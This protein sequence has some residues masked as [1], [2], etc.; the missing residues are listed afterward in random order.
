MQKPKSMA[1]VTKQSMTKTFLM[2]YIC[3]AHSQFALLGG[4]E[5]AGKTYTGKVSFSILTMDFFAQFFHRLNSTAQLFMHALCIICNSDFF[6]SFLT[7]T[8]KYKMV[9]IRISECLACCRVMQGFILL[10]FFQ[11]YSWNINLNHSY[12]THHCTT[13]Q[14]LGVLILF[15]QQIINTCLGSQ[16]RVS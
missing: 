9:S 4:E 16:P 1:T 2:S 3:T 8:S 13:S 5:C 11:Q 15:D 12:R 6:L 10:T 14:L 7:L